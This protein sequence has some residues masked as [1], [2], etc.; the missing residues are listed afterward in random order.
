MA[1]G[2]L[3]WDA[4][5]ERFYHQGVDRG[6]LYP[7]GTG[8]AY[9]DGVAWNG[10]T[11][12]TESPSGG[13]ETA[14]YAGNKKYGSMRASE[15]FGATIKAYTY[16]DEFSA[17]DGSLTLVEGVTAGQQTRV[18]FGL[19]FRSN[20][21]NDVSSTLG[22]LLHL[23]YGATASPSEK[24]YSTIND[25]P[26]ALEFSWDLTTNPVVINDN[27]KPTA[28]LVIDSRAVDATKLAALEAILYGAD[29]PTPTAPRLPLPSEIITLMTPAG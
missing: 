3:I 19:A 13:D 14:L 23:I 16:P 24:D 11:D 29:T 8:G 1:A 28:S 6:V 27:Y 2:K 7:V 10:L 25:K 26:D 17:C 21:G 18:A 12:V 5:G 9:S 22:Y 15:D 4:D 20:I